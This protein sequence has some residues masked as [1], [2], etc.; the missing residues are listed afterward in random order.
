M[1]LKP[2][3]AAANPL[4][5]FEGQAIGALVHGGICLVGTNHNTFQGAVVCLVAVMCALLNGTFD[6]LVSIAVHSPFLLLF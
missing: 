4:F 6:A 3:A 1:T 2:E 5:L